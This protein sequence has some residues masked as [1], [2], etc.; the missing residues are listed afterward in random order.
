[1]TVAGSAIHFT[2]GAALGAVLLT[3]AMF[4]V[5]AV[6]APKGLKSNDFKLFHVYSKVPYKC[7]LHFFTIFFL[8]GIFPSY[9]VFLGTLSLSISEKTSLFCT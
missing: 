1:M 2:L 4:G 7:E 8:F 3:M 5:L 6:K 9:T